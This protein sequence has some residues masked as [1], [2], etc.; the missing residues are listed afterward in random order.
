MERQLGTLGLGRAA[1]K[2][3]GGGDKGRR[4]LQCGA[5]FGGPPQPD[6]LYADGRPE[7]VV[8]KALPP[9]VP[10][11]QAGHPSWRRRAGESS[12]CT[13]PEKPLHLLRPPNLA[14]RS[15]LLRVWI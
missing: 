9:A 10:S 7:T 5:A 13:A 2:W 14:P 8:L 4:Q 11:S 15:V 6:P 12:H 1:Q 3:A